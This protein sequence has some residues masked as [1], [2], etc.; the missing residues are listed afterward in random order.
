M[1][2]AEGYWCSRNAVQQKI[3]EKVSFKSTFAG[4]DERESLTDDSEKIP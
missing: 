2:G 4:V 3:R 1:G